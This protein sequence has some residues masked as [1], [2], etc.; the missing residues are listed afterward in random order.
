MKIALALSL[1]AA[2][3]AGSIEARHG[4]C[5][6]DNCARQVTGTRDGLT[7]I[8]SRKNDCSNFMKTTLVPEATTVTVTVTVNIG[9]DEHASVTKRG[10]MEHRAATEAPSV[11]PAYAS[12]CNNPG[13]YSS[14]CSCWGITAV[15]T[16]AP[17]PT[18]V[19]TVTVTADYCE[20]L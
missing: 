14:A 17:V 7:A 1:I 16:T 19:A 15:T 5:S 4:H 12:S 20:D 6:G 2:A 18:H 8:T 13:K 11:V 10:D 9:S 3:V